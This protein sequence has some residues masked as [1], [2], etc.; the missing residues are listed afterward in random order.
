MSDLQPKQGQAVISGEVI[1]YAEQTRGSYVFQNMI[2]KTGTAEYPKFTPVEIKSD[3]VPKIAV[4]LGDIIK[5][6]CWL[7]GSKGMYGDNN[8]R[9]YLSLSLISLEVVVSAGLD[10]EAQDGATGAPAPEEEEEDPLP[11]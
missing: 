6:L 9:A 5:V 8:D 4:K 11:F 10:N 7:N 3:M 1:V 2:L